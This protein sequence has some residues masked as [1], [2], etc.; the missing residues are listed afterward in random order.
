MA[1]RIILQDPDERLRKTSR[2]VKEISPRIIQLLDDMRETL[3]T[4]KGYGLAAPQVGVLRRIFITDMCDGKGFTEFI[5]PEIISAEGEQTGEEGCLSCGDRRGVVTRPMKVVCRALN[6]NGE[7]VEHHAEGLFARCICHECAHLDG[8]LFL[9][10]MEQELDPN[11]Y[12]SEEDGEVVTED[13]D[14]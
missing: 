14:E 13:D 7:L 5:N 3:T 12:Y 6:R 10:L 9:D 8:G 11:Q 2:E 4:A 1:L